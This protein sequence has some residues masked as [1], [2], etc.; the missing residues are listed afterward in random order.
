[1]RVAG[2]RAGAE[3]RWEVDLEGG[4]LLEADA[5]VIATESA[6]ALPLLAEADPSL[7]E[8]A[9]LEWPA[10]STVELVT[11]VLDAPALDAAPRGT[12]ML[13]A[14]TVDPERIAAKALTHASAKWPW[15]ARR[16]PAGR[17]VLRLSYGRAGVGSPIEGMDDSAV[18]A[19]SL[20]DA[21]ALLDIPLS[22]SMVVGWTRKRWVNALPFAA[23][24]ERDRI[25]AVRD[26]VG[27][28]PGLEV[29]GSWLA[30][31]GLASVVP[32][33]RGAAARVRGLR[34]RMLTEKD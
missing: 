24:G 21:S 33:A 18:L 9:R 12:G 6:A 11:L 26:A 5:V 19:R 10:A 8:L 20:R 25:A 3:S 1:V 29:T 23:A 17:H 7:A 2:L 22:E 32:D 4:T 15:L 14:E 13:V 16:L 31:T 30:G 34:W 28:V 27:G